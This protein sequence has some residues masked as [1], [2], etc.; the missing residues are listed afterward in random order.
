[1][2]KYWFVLLAKAL[3]AFPGGFGTMDELFE[4]LTLVQTGKVTTAPPI[5]LFGSDF[6]NSVVNFEALV[7]WGTISPEDLDL[8][9][10][11]DTVEEARDTIIEQLTA[12]FLS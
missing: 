7:E 10:V 6:W 4:I 2:R 5:V 8:F 12:R 1:V 11:V 3:I 9:K